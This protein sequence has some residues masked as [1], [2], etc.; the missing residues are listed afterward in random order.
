[1]HSPGGSREMRAMKHRLSLAEKEKE[2]LQISLDQAHDLCTKYKAE[3]EVSKKASLDVQEKIEQ[4]KQTNRMLEQKLLDSEQ[5]IEN[6]HLQINE[7]Q[8]LDTLE[9]VQQQHEHYIQQ[10]REQYESDLFQFKE[11]FGESQR[12]LNNK[13]E[14][15]DLLKA[16]LETASKNAEMA[17][18][19]RADT[20]NRLTKSLN[21][22]QVKYDQDILLVLNQPKTNQIDDERL[23]LIDELNVK[24]QMLQEQLKTQQTISLR[25][26]T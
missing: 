3:T 11:K 19:E 12:E 26:S 4:L 10:L 9:R 5:D 6:L 7:Q 16:Q 18:I 20:I 22:L 24:C 14:L 8:K 13:H 21:D 17:I 15:I 2:S 1:L 25:H 23:K